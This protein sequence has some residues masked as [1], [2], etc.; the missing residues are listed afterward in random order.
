[1][2]YTGVIGTLKGALD[3]PC[4][5]LRADM[6][7]LPGDIW[8]FSRCLYMLS[9]YS[10]FYFFFTSHR[11]DWSQL[12]FHRKDSLRGSSYSIS[13]AEDIYLKGSEVGVMHACGHDCHVAILMGPFFCAL[14]I[15]PSLSRLIFF[16]VP[17]LSHPCFDLF[18]GVAQIFAELR[19]HLK[20]TVVF[21]FQVNFHIKWLLF[22][23]IYV[24][25]SRRRCACW[26]GGWCRASS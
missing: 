14:F 18:K 26:W 20:G 11:R 15:I 9:F 6:D 24:K 21:V 12:P 25:A 22:L 10:N 1:M 8:L 19:N 17:S 16:C 23:N 13:R 2:A 5:A 7:A 3:G 4:V